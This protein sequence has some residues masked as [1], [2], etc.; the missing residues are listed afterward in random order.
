MSSKSRF[1]KFRRKTF[2]DYEFGPEDD[3]QTVRMYPASYAMAARL[4]FMGTELARLLGH[5]QGSGS[6]NDIRTE[7]IY[8]N[9]ED[10]DGYKLSRQH[11]KPRPVDELRQL[12][13]QA[14]KTWK[15]MADVL[16]QEVNLRTICELVLDS[17]RDELDDSDRKSDGTIKDEVIEEFYRETDTRTVYDLLAGW[18]KANA[19]EVGDLGKTV[20]DRL[21]ATMQ[22]ALADPMPT[23]EEPE[24]GSKTTSSGD[25]S[26]LEPTS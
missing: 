21:R 5:M 6:K 12:G 10:K 18:F 22:G 3:R 2:I 1:G 24:A 20:T 19:G 11:M 23:T 9:H 8:E 17:M 16:T 25:S 26:S 13:E 14:G 15:E 4:R 7:V